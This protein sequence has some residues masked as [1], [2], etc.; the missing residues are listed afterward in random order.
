MYSSTNSQTNRRFRSGHYVMVAA[1]FFG[2]CAGGPAPPSHH[3][4]VGSS[5]ARTARSSSAEAAAEAAAAAPRPRTMTGYA[6]SSARQESSRSYS[7]RKSRTYTRH[8]R[9]RDRSKARP[10]E[11][12]GLATKAGEFRYSRVEREA[13]VRRNPANP[14][15]AAAI[16]YNNLAGIYAQIKHRV[17][18]TRCARC[19][20]GYRLSCSSGRC[21][22]V[23]RI[24]L[25]RGV[26][27]WLEDGRGRM[28][29]GVQ[30]HGRTYVIGRSNQRY[31][32]VIRN[33]TLDRFEVVA[34]V[35]GLDVV[36]RQPASLRRRGYVLGPRE[37]LRIDGFRVDTRRVAA[38]R[39]GSVASSLAAQT[40][41][42][43]N[44]GVIGVAVFA[45]RSHSQRDEAHL[46]STANPFPL[47][48][49]SVR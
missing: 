2:G 44:V 5:G 25:R 45:E 49:Q 10:H 6:D 36:S 9:R 3:T 32:I 16:R 37:T 41:G 46:R 23:E 21:P 20:A 28:L 1:I 24:P 8:L 42:H 48:N 13:F 43:R 30:T 34:S 39:F 18:Y 29:P 15:G 47:S 33:K 11:R 12:P 40:H 38:F 27:I 4:P 17:S 35:D 14:W 26:E 31:Q 19:P 22:L 7:P